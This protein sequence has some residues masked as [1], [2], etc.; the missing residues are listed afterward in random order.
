ML[1]GAHVK[2]NP[3]LQWQ[4]LQPTRRLFHQNFRI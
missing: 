4:K 2:L 1:Q 3:G